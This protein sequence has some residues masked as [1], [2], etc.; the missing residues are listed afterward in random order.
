VRVYDAKS[1]IR[2]GLA[3]LGKNNRCAEQE[4]QVCAVVFKRSRF[5]HVLTLSSC[6]S[7]LRFDANDQV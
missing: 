5:E 4:T 2:S 3:A 1:V 6:G 7:S